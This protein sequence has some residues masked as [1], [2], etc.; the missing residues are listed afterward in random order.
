MQALALVFA[1][2]HET[3]SGGG[4]ALALLV[5]LLVLWLLFR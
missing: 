4:E 1:D 3:S 2:G 5:V